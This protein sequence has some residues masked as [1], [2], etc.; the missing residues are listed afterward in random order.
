MASDDE[1]ASGSIEAARLF[2][3]I[4]DIGCRITGSGESAIAVAVM[5]FL[6]ALVAEL[7]Q[8]CGS[9][10]SGEDLG[11]E[12]MAF[13]ATVHESF[14]A[15][16]LDEGRMVSRVM[17]G[18]FLRRILILCSWGCSSMTKLLRTVNG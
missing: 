17:L 10:I 1:L 8:A 2:G 7:V 6:R 14:L 13:P 11:R 3:T 18:H 16:F 4:A 15:A 12:F 9:E 5:I